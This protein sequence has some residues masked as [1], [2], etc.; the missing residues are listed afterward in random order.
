LCVLH[1]TYGQDYEILF[2]AVIS[3]QYRH[4]YRVLELAG[5]TAVQAADGLAAVREISSMLMKRQKGDVQYNQYDAVL[6]DSE[7]PKM[8]GPEATREMRAMGYLGPI[9][10]VT[11][12]TD[13]TEFNDAGADRVLLKPVNLADVKK[14][15]ACR[16][17]VC[18]MYILK[19]IYI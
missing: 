6:M 1:R 3:S 12:N 13:H 17:K 11:G 9:I 15:L 18:I 16:G 5:H 14:A 8:S 2:H 4:H 10:G 19:R 7:M